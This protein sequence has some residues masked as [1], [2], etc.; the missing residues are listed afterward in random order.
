VTPMQQQYVRV[1]A[2]WVVVLVALY[3]FQQYFTP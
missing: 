3:A 1:M 2:V